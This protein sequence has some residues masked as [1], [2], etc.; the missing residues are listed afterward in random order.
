L[1]GSGCRRRPLDRYLTTP[2]TTPT[3][4]LSDPESEHD[5]HG[6][7]EAVKRVVA[8]MERILG[9]D[10]PRTLTSRHNLALY[11]WSAGG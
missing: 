1:N 6:T 8:D 5:R 7:P 10:D 3:F 2:E 4:K 11:Y 9:E